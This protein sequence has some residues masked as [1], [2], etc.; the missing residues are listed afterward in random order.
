MVKEREKPLSYRIYEGVEAL[1]EE[2]QRLWQ[3]AKEALRTSYSPYSDFP[4]GAALL[5]DNGS[6]VTGSNQENA[7]F[8]SGIC[9]ERVAVWKAA[10]ADPSRRFQALALTTVANTG[11]APISPCGSC[12]QVLSE[13]EERSGDPLRVLFPGGNGN[14]IAID[15]VRDLLP[16]P[17]KTAS[18]GKDEGGA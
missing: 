18:L 7:A 10:T 6:V 17:F 1:R 16:F 13:F 8:P 4:V 3:S 5:L 12:R 14:I 9:A 11:S 15:R 2:E